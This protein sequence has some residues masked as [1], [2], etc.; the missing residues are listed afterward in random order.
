MK[1]IVSKSTQGDNMK[2]ILNRVIKNIK[3]VNGSSLAE[4]ATTTALMATLAATAAPKLSEMAEGSKQ[5][6]TMNEIDK[7]MQQGQQFYQDTA[8]LEGRGRFPGQGR[9]DMAVG[10]ATHD[11]R[12]PEAS[13]SLAVSEDAD[14]ALDFFGTYDATNDSWSGGTYNDFEDSDA[15]IAWLSVFGLTS[16]A[17][18]PTNHGL[19]ADDTKN[20]ESASQSECSNCQGTEFTGHEEWLNAFGGETLNSPYQDGHYVYRVV[21]GYGSGNTAVPPI[22]YVADIENPANF[23]AVLMP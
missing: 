14:S 5:E 3:S 10:G 1:R 19:H 18:K 12:S 9:F 8:D 15:S 21:P 17:T 23:N 2:H 16:E 13:N 6:K 11:G 7:I 22:L 20:I 4:F